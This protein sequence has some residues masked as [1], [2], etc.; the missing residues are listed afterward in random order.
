M[1]S[2]SDSFAFLTEKRVPEVSVKF[3]FLTYND[4]IANRNW[5]IIIIL[6]ARSL[7]Y[8][9]QQGNIL[10]VAFKYLLAYK[11]VELQKFDEFTANCNQ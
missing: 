5:H 9:M 2:S 11:S 6:L 8:I 1:V 10:I 3:L 7:N 4:S